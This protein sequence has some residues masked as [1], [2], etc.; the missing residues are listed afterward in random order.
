MAEHKPFYCTSCKSEKDR[1]EMATKD[2]CHVCEQARLDLISLQ[3][4]F[5]PTVPI[6]VQVSKEAEKTVKKIMSKL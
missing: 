5:T 2:R 4:K 3:Y 1:D 6:R